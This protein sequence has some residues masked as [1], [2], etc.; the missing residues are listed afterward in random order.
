M[1]ELTPAEASD[2][3]Q[4][5][6]LRLVGSVA[7]A[8]AY[9]SPFVNVLE[10]GTFPS[11]VSDEVR[12]AIQMPA[13]PGD[14]LA[15]PEF[16]D[17][18]E[19]CGT[20]G[21]QDLTDAI[22]LTYR[23]QT[24]RGQGPRVCVK[25]GYAAFKSSYLAAEDSLKKLIVQYVNA[26]TRA[27]LYL[28]SGSKFQAKAGESFETLFQGGQETDIGVLFDPAIVP[29]APLTFQA[30]HA[31]ARHLKESVLAEMF[32]ADG[33]VQPHFK[34]IGSSDI[35]ES[36]RAETGVKE[37]LIALTQGSY[38]LGENSV[39]AYSWETSPAYRGIA[40]G[41][42]QR[43]LRA[44]FIHAEGDE[45]GTAALVNPVTLVEN[46]TKNTAYAVSNPTWRNADLEIGFLIAQGTFERQVPEKYV[47]EGSFKFPPQLHMGELEWYFLRD[48]Q[49]RFGDFGQHIYQITRAYR[50]IRPNHI[51]PIIYRK[52]CTDLGL[53]ATEPC[54]S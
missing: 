34:F 1:D 4:K 49:N 32:P 41:T 9:N 37:I 26:D 20:E 45:A 3:A 36:F 21:P 6:T 22:N 33:K 29:D 25:K 24:K 12:S 18:T 52:P 8:L 15:I 14:S 23:L 2:I 11:G 16:I 43:P 50:P 35:I 31:I 38:K 30:L 7:K 48:L 28:R 40:L 46:E 19:V 47:G 27:Q 39:S 51:V 5:D 42:D 54:G 17:D 53:V 10:G 13:A 44:P